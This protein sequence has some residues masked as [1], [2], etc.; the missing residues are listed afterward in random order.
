MKKWFAGF[1]AT[2]AV[3]VPGCL[4]AGWIGAQIPDESLGVLV[5]FFL[6]MPVGVASIAAGEA[7]FFAVEEREWK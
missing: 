7:A 1:G 6:G 2:L 4:V 3:F 5:S